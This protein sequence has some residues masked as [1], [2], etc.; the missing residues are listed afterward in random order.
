MTSLKQPFNDM[1]EKVR[2]HSGISA[3]TSDSDLVRERAAVKALVVD[4]GWSDDK[5][6]SVSF[7]SSDDYRSA[8]KASVTEFKRVYEISGQHTMLVAGHAS[9]SA[10]KASVGFDSVAKASFNP[11]MASLNDKCPR[12]N[13]SM[14]PV[15]LA[16]SKSAVYCRKDRIAIP[17]DKG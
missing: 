6:A 3:G 15:G 5:G 17:L 4:A 1:W 9:G 10:L 16:N 12:C 13:S 7:T 11:V 2:K 14:E 8:I